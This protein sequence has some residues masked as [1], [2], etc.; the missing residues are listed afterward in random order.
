MVE[1]GDWKEKLS[2]LAREKLAKIGE[3]SPEEKE[4]IKNQQTLKSVLAEFYTGQL[5]SE[6]LWRR[7]RD[8][9]KPLLLREA[10]INLLDSLS[11]G[12]SRAEFQKRRDSIL[13]IET[14][15]E[16][17]NTSLVELTLNSLESLQKRFQ[18]EKEK[19]YNDFKAQVE[20]N[21]Q[22]R[23]QQQQVQTQRGTAIVQIQLS[24]EETIKA[25]PQWKQF[26]SEHEKRYSQ[27]F[28]KVKEKLKTQVNR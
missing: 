25:N 3:I 27:E 14:L 5:D 12:S 7:L 13:V 20:R 21:P 9:G 17:Q 18:E 11:L 10:Q 15:K 6:G 19:V 28:L 2:P 24:V 22:L 1:M 16:E 26:L 4:S 8:E 23:I